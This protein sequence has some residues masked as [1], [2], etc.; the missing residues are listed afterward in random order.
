M[1]P[2]GYCGCNISEKTQQRD[3]YKDTYMISQSLA[4]AIS[5]RHVRS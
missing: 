5:F 1:K 3:I 4:C 2:N